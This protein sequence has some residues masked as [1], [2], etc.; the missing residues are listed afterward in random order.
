MLSAVTATCQGHVS[1]NPPQNI[2][3][4]PLLDQ[5]GPRPTSCHRSVGAWG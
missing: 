5:T 2:H 3:A 1:P 4:E